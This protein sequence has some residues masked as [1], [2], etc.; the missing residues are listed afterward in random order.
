MTTKHQKYLFRPP[1]SVL[2]NTKHINHTLC[3]NTIS[4]NLYLI[5]RITYS[6]FLDFHQTNVVYDIIAQLHKNAFICVLAVTIHFE[7]EGQI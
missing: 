4:N 7:F 6:Y 3:L 1:N 2:L 5:C